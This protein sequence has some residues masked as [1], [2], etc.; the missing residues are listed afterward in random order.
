MTNVGLI[1]MNDMKSLAEFNHRRL[2]G[3]TL[4]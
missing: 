3:K 1:L 2:S 4:F